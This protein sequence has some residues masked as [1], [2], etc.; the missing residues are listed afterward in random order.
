MELVSKKTRGQIF[1]FTW[2]KI[3]M[4]LL[5]LLACGF[6]LME[7]AFLFNPFILLMLFLSYQRSGRAYFITFVSMLCTA[8]L[9][10]IAYGLEIIL[11]SVVYFFISICFQ[12]I[13]FHSSYQR[14]YSLLTI[15]ILLMIA[16]IVRTPTINSAF[17]CLTSTFISLLF[18][19]QL[20][21]LFECYEDE[22]LSISPLT[23]SLFLLALHFSSMFW[24]ILGFIMIRLIALSLPSSKKGVGVIFL[25]STFISLVHFYHYS[26]IVALMVVLPCLVSLCFKKSYLAYGVSL[27]IISWALDPLFYTNGVFYQGIVALIISILFKKM[28]F[29]AWD[30]LINREEF[31]NQIL[32]SEY[33][34]NHKEK[35][36]GMIDYINALDFELG[37]ENMSP[38][39]KAG[40][41]VYREACAQCE[42]LSYCPLPS[43]L[44]SLV[45]YKLKTEQKRR[46][47][48]ECI[49]PYKLTLSL[50]Q[51]HAIYMTEDGYYIEALKRKNIL[52]NL[53]DKIRKPLIDMQDDYQHSYS[54]KEQIINKAGQCE[55]DIQNIRCHGSQIIVTLPSS[56]DNE[57]KLLPIL[58][59]CLDT[60]FFLEKQQRSW[61]HQN[62]EMVFTPIAEHLI[63]YTVHS[64]AAQKDAS[65]DY[66]I[67]DQKKSKMSILLCDG[68][69]HDK[70]A[71]HTSQ[72]LAHSFMT[73][74][75]QERNIISCL[76]DINALFRVSS[77]DDNYSTLDF[78]EIQLQTLECRFF[79]G[80]SAP[81]FI[82]RDNEIIT[83]PVGGL[84]IGLLDEIDVETKSIK[85][86][87]N[88]LLIMVSDGISDYIEAQDPHIFKN[89]N[90]PNSFFR[91][92]FQIAVE[93]MKHIDD[94][95]MIICHV[96]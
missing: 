48:K 26:L 10:N 4:L 61:L 12:K 66:Y 38:R 96:L 30:N 21:K 65:G 15:N 62:V 84:P 27:L 6:V 63:T 32:F 7:K 46:I 29:Q 22:S 54:V 91:H 58:N 9:V 8:S 60:N 95:T 52:S 50:Q 73:L 31:Q 13:A 3:D 44:Q 72:S 53:M 68:M 56:E 35:I 28:N 20:G 14:Y 36:Q 47:T 25:T 70:K 77:N 5:P 40:Q 82:I 86:Q 33:E 19:T 93:N 49:K 2:N 89:I 75:Q 23:L 85:L 83:I 87:K 74:Y 57:E 78:C 59:Q 51:S 16:M 55:I 80:G 94:A 69:G 79:K 43:D 90:D 39:Q 88:D 45:A 34:K 81:S 71:E 67:I 1:S 11:I 92:L 17:Y 42:H 37:Q 41:R 18:A 64:Q 24:P 76:E